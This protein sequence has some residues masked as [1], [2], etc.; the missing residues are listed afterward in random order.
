MNARI[1]VASIGVLIALVLAVCVGTMIHTE[2]S[3]FK[4]N[5]EQAQQR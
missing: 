3:E 4:A 2:M 5:F 1:Y